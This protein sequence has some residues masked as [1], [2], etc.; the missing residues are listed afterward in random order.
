[1]KKQQL[2]TLTAAIATASLTSCGFAEQ[3][4]IRLSGEHTISFMGDQQQVKELPVDCD[5]EGIY[6]PKPEH[7]PHVNKSLDQDYKQFFKIT[8]K[9][10]LPIEQGSTLTYSTYQENRSRFHTVITKKVM[11]RMDSPSGDGD[12]M[13]HTMV[14]NILPGMYDSIAAQLNDVVAE[15][16]SKPKQ[17]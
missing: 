1:M 5:A 3:K 13:A 4:D 2:L 8:E 17:G 15:T 12:V 10:D 6:F 14:R 7:D 16:C 11:E 9:Y